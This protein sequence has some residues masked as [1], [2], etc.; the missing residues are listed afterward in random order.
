MICICKWR[1]LEPATFRCWGIAMAI[2]VYTLLLSRSGYFMAEHQF[3]FTSNI[4]WSSPKWGLS[5]TYSTK[6]LNHKC[7]FWINGRPSFLL[8]HIIHQHKIHMY[9]IQVYLAF[10]SQLYSW[11]RSRILLVWLRL[12]CK[13][14]A[15]GSAVR[16]ISLYW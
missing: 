14:G 15:S 6:I 4:T 5:S 1:R 2:P 3:F 12:H 7:S 8:K 13:K 16:N 9:M 10:S 11:S